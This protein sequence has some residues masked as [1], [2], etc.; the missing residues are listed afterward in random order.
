MLDLSFCYVFI[1]VCI[2]SSD[3][4]VSPCH[5]PLSFGSSGKQ[6][7]HHHTDPIEFEVLL[8]VSEELVQSFD[9]YNTITTASMLNKTIRPTNRT[10]HTILQRPI[11]SLVPAGSN[12]QVVQLLEDLN[13]SMAKNMDVLVNMSSFKAC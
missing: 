4:V 10:Q 6:K 8:K 11:E 9:S 3:F 12:D 2:V 1:N 5:C 7:I 13:Q